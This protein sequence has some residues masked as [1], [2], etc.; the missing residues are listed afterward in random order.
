MR[1]GR[2]LIGSPDRGIEV[3][4]FVA[5]VKLR[6]VAKL[7]RQVDLGEV[8]TPSGRYGEP[9][10]DVESVGGV[11]AGIERRRAQSN[12]RIAPEG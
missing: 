7:V 1:L 3:A 11:D 4:V 2:E 9:G 6:G 8:E 10:R 5:A 12:R